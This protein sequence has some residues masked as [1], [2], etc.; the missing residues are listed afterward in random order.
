M[1]KITLY[2]LLVFSICFSAPEK[3]LEE[4]G[5]SVTVCEGPEVVYNNMVGLNDGNNIKIYKMDGTFVDNV[6]VPA[7]SPGWINANYYVTK[8]FIDSDDEW[9]ILRWGNDSTGGTYRIKTEIIDDNG[10][11][12][13]N[14]EGYSVLWQSDKGTYVVIHDNV[15]VKVAVYR[16]RND[17]PIRSTTSKYNPLSNI[18]TFM[19]GINSIKIKPIAGKN[20]TF[21]IYDLQGRLLN[22]VKIDNTNKETIIPLNPYASGN[23]ITTIKADENRINEK[24]QVVK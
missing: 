2:I 10:S 3:V 6:P 19:P 20:A 8:K 14:V 7:L 17:V 13:L 12:I 1:K 5:F 15:N 11:E 24:V 9:E 4:N 21:A 18:Q 23:Y 16:F 22:T